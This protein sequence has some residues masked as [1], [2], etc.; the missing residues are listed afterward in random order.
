M[1]FREL[2]W[3]KRGKQKKSVY[4]SIKYPMSP[5]EI[6]KMAKRTNPKITFGDVTNIIREAE[7]IEILVCLTPNRR[8]G[9]I[10]FYNEYGRNLVNNAYEIGV[11]KPNKD[12][13]W[14]EYAEVIAGRTRRHVLNMVDS[15]KMQF[16]EGMTISQIRRK[17]NPYYPISLNQTLSAVQSLVETGFIRLKGFT[18]KRNAKLYGITPE[19]SRTSDYLLRLSQ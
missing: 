12:I 5:A 7:K 18:K 19:G 4:S 14:N 6:Y 13:V 9:R 10:Y 2:G 11:R 3:I 1:K 17:V 8:T 16:P 15:M